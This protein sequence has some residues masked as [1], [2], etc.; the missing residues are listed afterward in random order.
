VLAEEAYQLTVTD[1]KG[2]VGDT[3][4]VDIALNNPYGFGGLAYD[5]IF[6]ST[7]LK[8]I[9]YTLGLGA[10]IC[11]DSGIDRYENKLN[12]QYGGL[13]NIEGDG[14]LVSIVFEII[15]SASTSIKVVPEK[16]T[17]FYYEGRKEINFTLSDAAGSVQISNY[18]KGDVTLDGNVNMDDVT[19]LMRH[20]LKAHTITN[21]EALA[22]G[23]VTGDG[24]LNMDDVT[25]LMRYVLK[26][27]DS[28]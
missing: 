28:L 13:K 5:V 18:E 22:L 8:P 11:V 16:G 15:G 9:S 27:I 24:T 19:A 25:K 4:T 26:A 17:T 21:T 23:E 1:V 10:D 7:V 3:V 6:D 20:I 12:F 14:V 2:S